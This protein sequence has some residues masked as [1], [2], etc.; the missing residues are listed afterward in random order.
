MV[1][2][3]G[4]SRL[5]CCDFMLRFFV[6][7]FLALFVSQVRAQAAWVNDALETSV[8]SAPEVNANYVG[9]IEAGA[10]IVVLE[11]SRDG[12]FARIESGDLTGWIWARNVMDR[13]SIHQRFEEQSARFL[14]LQQEA[15]DL[16]VQVRAQETE[17]EALRR[18]LGS[19]VEVGEE[20]RADLL[21][22]QRAS[23]NVMAIDQRNRQ[24]QAQV[25]ELER[26]HLQLQN[27]INRM[28]KERFQRQML[29]GAGLVVLGVVIA[30][31]LS[32]MGR[33]R[34]RQDLSDF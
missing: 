5:R 6:F 34:R 29:L 28:E 32:F 16:R 30:V 10:P 19:A 33:V 14:R 15:E 3:V 25:V 8:L 21:A 22:L 12:R 9:A 18:Q 24:L 7:L 13:P 31:L 20:A 11:R 4:A 17:L 27:Q 1:G 23:S 2:F 26:V